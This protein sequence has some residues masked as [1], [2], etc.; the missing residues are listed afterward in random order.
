VSKG[1]EFLAELDLEELQAVADTLVVCEVNRVIKEKILNGEPIYPDQ[2]ELYK[3]EVR[4]TFMKGGN[5]RFIEILKGEMKDAP[6]SVRTNI[7]G[8]QKNLAGMTDKLVNVWRQIVAAP[9]VLDDPR[10]AKILNQ[11]LEYS[12]LEPIDFYRPPTQ[13]LVSPQTKPLQEVAQPTFPTFT[14]Q[15]R[16]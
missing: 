9:Q 3:Q 12:D 2:V 15:T 14:N 13:P 6:I 1:K 10:M 16:N 4:D 7:V 11:I 8:K 5:K